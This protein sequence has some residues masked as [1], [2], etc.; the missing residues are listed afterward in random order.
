M[1]I[2]ITIPYVLVELF[3][4]GEDEDRKA[5]ADF[6]CEA[7]YNSLCEEVENGKD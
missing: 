1:L 5:I 2:K 7:I 3:Q 6:I 4:V